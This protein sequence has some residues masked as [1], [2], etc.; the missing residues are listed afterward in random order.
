LNPVLIDFSRT[1]HVH[2]VMDLVTLESDLIIR[3]LNETDIRPFLES[4]NVVLEDSGTA[5]EMPIGIPDSLRARKI[6]VVISLLRFKATTTYG[7]SLAEYECA[8]LLKT[9]EFLSLGKLPYHQHIRATQY[10]THLCKRLG[11]G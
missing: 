4:L 9:L 1:G 8:A 6:Y 2:S 5:G 10:V 3:G 7:V 11:L